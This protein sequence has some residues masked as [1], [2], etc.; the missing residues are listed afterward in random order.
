M[1]FPIVLGCLHYASLPAY[2]LCH[3]YL[4]IGPNTRITFSPQTAKEYHSER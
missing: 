3:P 1:G 4:F 2:I